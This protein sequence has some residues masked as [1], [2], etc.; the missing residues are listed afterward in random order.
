MY[1]YDNEYII[2]SHVLVASLMVLVYDTLLTIGNEIN[3]IWLQPWTLGSLLF[4]VNRYL[5]FLDTSLGLYLEFAQ[6]TPRQCERYYTGITWLIAVGLMVSELILLLRTW[7]LW[8]RSKKI[9]FILG[10]LSS[11]TFVPGIL[12][13][14]Y[15]IKSLRFGEVP[16]GG[17]GCNLLS[18][19]K[20][21]M[22][23]Y[24]LIALS[25]TIVV[26]LTIKKGW[27]HRARASQSSW[28][29]R[30]YRHGLLFYLYLLAITIIN[31]VVPLVADQP[32]YKNYL[33]VPQRVF[34]SIFCNRVILLIQRQRS[35]RSNPP[36]EVT[37]E[38]RSIT[39]GCT[40]NGLD[41]AID[42]RY[43]RDLDVDNQ[44]E[45]GQDEHEMST[46]RQDWTR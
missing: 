31:M 43:S 10:G 26:V 1:L 16:E 12:I 15:E 23:A 39:K 11:V 13:T 20:L 25:E 35:I 5:P 42:T 38:Q 28:V 33:A 32:R 9:F 7:A 19:S 27:E 30:V 34:H 46:Y 3:Y 8:D 22:A 6:T 29:N 4:M 37:Q 14:H 21:I 36:E 44:S 41:T 2:G 18:A 24:V 17:R 45:V 40:G